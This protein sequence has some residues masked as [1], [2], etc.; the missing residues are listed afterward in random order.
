[1]THG[2]CRLCAG[3]T[4]LV[5]LLDFGLMPPSRRFLTAELARQSEPVRPLR[6]L[7]CDSC[8]MLQ[9]DVF[10]DCQPR[11]KSVADFTELSAVD[12]PHALLS[13]LQST[14]TKDDILS[15]D[16]P[17]LYSL[18]Q[19]L[20]FDTICHETKCY[21]SIGQASALL[22]RYGFEIFDVEPLTDGTSRLRL[23]VQRRG[24]AQSI[25]PSITEAIER[26]RIAGLDRPRPWADFAHLVEMCRDLLT[27]ELNEWLNRGKQV[28]GWTIDGRGMTFL[29][30]CSIDTLRLSFLV[31]ESPAF[32]GLLTPGHR[33]PIVSPER[34]ER[35][36]PDVVLLLGQEWDPMRENALTDYWRRG[37]RVLTPLPKPHF[38]DPFLPAGNR[39]N[40]ERGRDTISPGLSFSEFA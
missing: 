26:E 37:G 29:A 33:I 39:L 27:S 2:Q 8:G 31:D 5:V 23:S 17:D 7:R 10:T 4:V 40:S 24:G 28:A 9:T 21:F 3:E 6:L 34:L 30:Y 22:R 20:G 12:D 38:V 19:R 16:I 32:R 35:E 25:R 14:G 18:H 15:V 11:T 1:M 13:A 36:H